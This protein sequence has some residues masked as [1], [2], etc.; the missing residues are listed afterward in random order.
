[1]LPAAEQLAELRR[2]TAEIL[3]EEDLL[4]KLARGKPLVV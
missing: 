1:M 3:L 2:G 4:R